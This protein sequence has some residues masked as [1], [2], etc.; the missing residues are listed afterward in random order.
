MME[1][2]NPFEKFDK[3]W[4]LVT[5]GTKDKFNTMTISWGSM[6]TLWFKSVITIYIRPDRYTFE[7]LENSDTFT[8]SFFHEDKKNI[9]GVLGRCSGR[10]MDKMRESGL[11]PKYLDNGITWGEAKKTYVCRKL[12]M[13][14]MDKS[15]FPPDA[16]KCYK[17][18]GPAHYIIIGEVIEEI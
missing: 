1:E 13:E 5:A 18:N 12:Y 3:E 8:V 14:Q 2:F 10:D 15:K 6:G 17:D 11:T 9:L 7:F 16:L 4:A